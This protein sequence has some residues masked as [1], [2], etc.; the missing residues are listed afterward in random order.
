MEVSAGH[1]PGSDD[2]ALKSHASASTKAALP[3]STATTSYPNERQAWMLEPTAEAKPSVSTFFTDRNLPKSA[4]VAT[5]PAATDRDDGLTEAERLN[6]N[7]EGEVDLFSSLG[8]EHKRKDPED[9]KPD[10]S[11]PVVSRRELNQQLVQGKTLDEYET[12]GG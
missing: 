1:A 9:N 5:R 8:T 2:L 4:G 12:K 7:V 3:S 11:K 6:R 10:P